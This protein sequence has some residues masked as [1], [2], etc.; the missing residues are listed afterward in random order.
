[1]SEPKVERGANV[2][3][4]TMAMSVIAH[5]ADEETPP[6]ALLARL[7]CMDSAVALDLTGSDFAAMWPE[8]TKAVHASRVDEPAA[9]TAEE[10]EEAPPSSRR[11]LKTRRD[12][13]ILA[14]AECG[15]H[16][17]GQL[18]PRCLSPLCGA[19]AVDRGLRKSCE[20]EFR[21]PTRS[22]AGARLCRARLPGGLPKM[23]VAGAVPRQP[24]GER[25]AEAA[26]SL[27]NLS[28]HAKNG[29]LMSRH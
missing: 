16:T 25:T 28:S 13:P 6:R 9:T 17:D 8:L 11:T 18:C 24:L 27:L 21:K 20:T 29:G 23:E 26:A 10:E 19:H 4:C 15:I 1:M 22:R 12:V 7:D 5:V 14:C 3:T 2:R